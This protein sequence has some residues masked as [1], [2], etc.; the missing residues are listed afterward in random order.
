MARGIALV[1]GVLQLLGV[2]VTG[3]FSDLWDALTGIGLGY[4]VAGW[5]LQT[6]QTT[7]TA[8]GWYFILRA[9]YPGRRS[10]T[11]RCSRRTPPAS[12]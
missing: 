4:L 12:R 2:D 10:S 6:V 8:L 11:G 5:S 9:A 3:W 1:V 7:L